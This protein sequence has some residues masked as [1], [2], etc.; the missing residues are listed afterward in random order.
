MRPIFA[1]FCS[2][3]LLSFATPSGAHPSSGP[4]YTLDVN[5]ASVHW[6]K[7]ARDS[8]NQVNPGLG[9]TAHFSPDWGVSAGFYYNSFRRTSTYVLASWTP[10]HLP[11]TA[12]GWRLDA[13]ADAGILTG[14]TN[15]EL[16][17]RPFGAAALLRVHAPNGMACSLLAIPNA[18]GRRSGFVGAQVS[19]PI[20]L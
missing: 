4:R 18:P 19:F 12:S 6:E 1:V 15:A 3:L 2:V 5:L 20:N 10:L 7:W 13:G 11:L 14:Y 16:G 17:A 9:V 8:L